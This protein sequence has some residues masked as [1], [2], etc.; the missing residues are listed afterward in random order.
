MKRLLT[1][2]FALLVAGISAQA[3][4]DTTTF[5]AEGG[6]YSVTGIS[7]DTDCPFSNGSI[8]L[9]VTPDDS[10]NTYSYM[11]STGDTTQDLTGLGAG[12]YDVTVTRKQDSLELKAYFT[13]TENGAPPISVINVRNLVC[14]DGTNGSIVLDSTNGHSYLWENGSTSHRRDGLSAGWYWVQVLDAPNFC[15]RYE[16]FNISGPAPIEFT[17]VNSEEDCSDLAGGQGLLEVSASGGTPPYTYIWNNGE[18]GPL[19]ENLDS[20][21]YLLIVRDANNCS[22]NQIFNVAA[23]EC[24]DEP[25][26]VFVSELITA[27]GDG[28]NDVLEIDGLNV[29]ENHRLSI[30]NRYGN[31]VYEAAP[32]NNDWAGTLLNGNELLPEGTYFYRLELRNLSETELTGFIV[33]RH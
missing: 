11:W 21:Q 23:R 29:Y 2:L 7:T 15:R 30:F 1:S 12:A 25:V 16:Y 19:I 17:L 6:A 18:N 20:G 5:T 10:L 22:E 26:D 13:I 24:T 28:Y 9:E 3:Q 31:I 32:Y 27:N 33:I 4:S 14:H 8:N